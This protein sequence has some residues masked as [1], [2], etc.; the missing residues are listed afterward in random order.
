MFLSHARL[1][2]RQPITSTLD[3]L[4]ALKTSTAS[5]LLFVVF[6]CDLW[7]TPVARHVL[8]ETSIF[9]LLL[10][11]LQIAHKRYEFLEGATLV[12]KEYQIYTDKSINLLSYRLQI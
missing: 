10:F 12:Q 8:R 4:P 6:L 3:L 1:R 2:V 7:D 11:L 5:L 9:V